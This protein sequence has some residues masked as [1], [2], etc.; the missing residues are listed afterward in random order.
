M[1]WTHELYIENIERRL[2]QMSD[3]ITEYYARKSREEKRDINETKKFLASK[4]AETQIILNKLL[5]EYEECK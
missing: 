5:K 1:N 4:I 2:E 3:G